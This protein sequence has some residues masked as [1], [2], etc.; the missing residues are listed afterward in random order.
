M[1]NYFTP[2]L[3]LIRGVAGS[4]KTTY[5]K[6]HLIPILRKETGLVQ[7]PHFEADD[8]WMRRQ[9]DGSLKYVFEP[10]KLGL[11]HKTCLDN[12]KAAFNSADFHTVV[13]VSNTFTTEKEMKP[14]IEFA[15][16]NGIEVNVI[17]MNTWYGSIHDV[18][19]DVIDSMRKRLEANP[20]PYETVIG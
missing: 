7:I 19:A 17:R 20:Y 1:P 15:E 6:N 2:A 13:V 4:G 12:M 14:Y 11:A 10:A 9:S 8:F 18:P 16:Q 3:Y 5:A